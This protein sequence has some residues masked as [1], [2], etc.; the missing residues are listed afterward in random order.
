MEGKDMLYAFTAIDEKYIEASEKYRKDEK[1]INEAM[2]GRSHRKA[3]VAAL[4]AIICMAVLSVVVIK[5][6]ISKWNKSELLS[7]EDILNLE[8]GGGA[9][10]DVWK[11]YPS[12]QPPHSAV[13]FKVLKAHYYISKSDGENKIGNEGLRTYEVEITKV[14]KEINGQELKEG[15]HVKILFGDATHIGFGNVEDYK[16]AVKEA[17]G[18]IDYFGKEFYEFKL[19]KKYN[20]KIF[21]DYD[22]NFEGNI[23]FNEGEEY[24]AYLYGSYF[25][26]YFSSYAAY[27]LN[28][29]EEVMRAHEPVYRRGNVKVK[30]GRRMIEIVNGNEKDLISSEVEFNDVM[31][32]VDI[33]DLPVI[34]DDK[35]GSIE[36]LSDERY[37]MLDNMRKDDGRNKYTLAVLIMGKPRYYINEDNKIICVYE[38]SG[39][40]MADK[41]NTIGL[42]TNENHYF[43]DKH[44]LKAVAPSTYLRLKDES[45]LPEIIRKSI[46]TLTI[47]KETY[48][49]IYL[50][51]QYEYELV[52]DADGAIILSSGQYAVELNTCDPILNDKGIYQIEYAYPCD[53]YLKELW[54]GEW[55]DHKG[56][57][58][59]WEGGRMIEELIWGDTKPEALKR[60]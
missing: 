2:R 6:L 15:D 55:A 29:A 31:D 12:T 22:Y 25:D 8:Y 46:G 43:E 32:F 19:Y 18:S 17:E 38:V 28:N 35:K 45:K 54:E 57:G 48:Y 26:G 39:G 58:I 49:E 10:V 59:R 56:T 47:G 34:Y 21:S 7:Y 13:I 4:S 53:S 30:I 11:G 16:E 60:K 44:R 42:K 5:P 9:I 24:A 14:N 33:W 27:P 40:W 50:E 37:D 52:H 1:M 51:R 3:A 41:Y 23:F 20:L 36:K